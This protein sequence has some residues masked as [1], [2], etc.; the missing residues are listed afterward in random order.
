MKTILLIGTILTGVLLFS[1]IVIGLRIGD[2]QPTDRAS[3]KFHLLIG[4]MAAIVSMA[5]EIIALVMVYRG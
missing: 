3:S 1:T 2:H 4:V 5:T